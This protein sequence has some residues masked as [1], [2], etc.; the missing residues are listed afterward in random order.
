MVRFLIETRRRRSTSR[1]ELLARLRTFKLLSPKRALEESV[2]IELFA[3][4]RI[5]SCGVSRKDME[6][7]PR[8]RLFWRYSSR[9]SWWSSRGISYNPRPRQSTTLA[10]VSHEHSLGQEETVWNNKRLDNAKTTPSEEIEKWSK[11][12]LDS[13]GLDFSLFCFSDKHYINNDDTIIRHEPVTYNSDENI[14]WP[15]GVC[16][17]LFFI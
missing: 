4:S 15:N 17:L 16:Y 9:V 10:W 6:P 3:R 8:R 14:K 11:L 13:F 1:I 2:V 5:W 12:P 7:R